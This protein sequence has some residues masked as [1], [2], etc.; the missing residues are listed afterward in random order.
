[1]DIT[2]GRTELKA[3]EYRSI[4]VLNSTILPGAKVNMSIHKLYM[5]YISYTGFTSWC[6]KISFEYTVAEVR[7]CKLPWRNCKHFKD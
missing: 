5:S 4:P 2:D 3:M 1:M 6:D 7:E